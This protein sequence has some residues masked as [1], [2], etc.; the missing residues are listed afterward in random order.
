MVNVSS[1]REGMLILDFFGLNASESE[2]LSSTGAPVLLIYL[3]V[4]P[5][6]TLMGLGTEFEQ[7]IFKSWSVIF[8]LLCVV[9][10]FEVCP[11]KNPESL[12]LEIPAYSISL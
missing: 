12:M 9:C 6:F 7:L 4:S 10:F 11:G 3:T 5:S 2:N 1:W 8:I